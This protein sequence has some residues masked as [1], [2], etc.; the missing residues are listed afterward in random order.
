MRWWLASLTV[1]LLL[2][3]AQA[4]KG[5]S[6]SSSSGS[7]G[8]S[9]SSTTKSGWGGGSSGSSR[10]STTKSGW[11]GATSGSSSPQQKTTSDN[12]SAKSGWGGS[13]SGSSGSSKSGWGGGGATVKT[14]TPKPDATP[15]SVS[16][17]PVA[18]SFDRVA[19]QEA[20]RA[21]SRANY[22]KAKEPAP[23]FKTPAGKEV[24][25]KKDST[26]AFRQKFD[27][28]K[29]TSW[30]QRETIHYHRYVGPQYP[31]IYY[32]DPYHPRF[33]YWLMA[34][35]LDTMALFIHHHQDQMNQ[36]RIR[37]LYAKNA[38]LEAQVQNLKNQPVNHSWC[39]PGADEDLLYNKEFVTSVYNP[40]PK[41][42]DEYTY[43]DDEQSGSSVFG[44]ICLGV[45]L[46]LWVV[47]ILYFALFVV[48]Y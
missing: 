36:E 45:T 15:K 34:Q 20:N 11:G 1:V 10:S 12:K 18:P 46:V 32:S 17:R 24:P 8:S 42:V 31:P 7:S 40:T 39:P 22:A 48:R 9:R 37:D 35:S 5:R 27:E 21:E 43:D 25:I 33:N 6:S 4:Q 2:L 3:P 38:K 41:E 19:V 16:K 14:T 29:W 26:E 23:S 28:Q 47:L 44:M 30:P 13:A